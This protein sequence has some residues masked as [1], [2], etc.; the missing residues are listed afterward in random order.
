MQ[1]EQI[2]NR[3][4]LQ[5]NVE[6]PP[7]VYHVAIFFPLL[8][9][10]ITIFPCFLHP[11]SPTTPTYGLYWRALKLTEGPST[12]L[13]LLVKTLDTYTVHIKKVD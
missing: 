2:E 4:K 7:T 3:F 6:I 8:P 1:R 13:L 11:S 5:K 12:E 9:I 10:K